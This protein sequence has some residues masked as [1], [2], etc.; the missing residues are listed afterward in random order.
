MTSTTHLTFVDVEGGQK[1]AVLTM[2][3]P[4]VRVFSLIFVVV[5]LLLLLA[6]AAMDEEEGAVSQ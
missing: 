5:D 2:D 4:P 6:T 3:N 1:V